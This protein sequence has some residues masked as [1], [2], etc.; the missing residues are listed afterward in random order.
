MKNTILKMIEAGFT[1]AE[2][3]MLLG[4]GEKKKSVIVVLW[5]IAF[6][7]SMLGFKRLISFIF[8]VCGYAYLIAMPFTI[9]RFC[10]VR[11]KE[12]K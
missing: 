6:A 4:E 2:I 8:P 1:K 5:V 10:I 3:M 9:R 12:K 7:C 11:K